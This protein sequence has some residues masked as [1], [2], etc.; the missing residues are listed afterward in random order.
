MHPLPSLLLTVWALVS[1]AA[2][3]G[4]GPADLVPGG[5]IQE[6]P[7]RLVIVGGALAGDNAEIYG[8]ILGGREGVGPLCVFPTASG[9]PQESM[10]S[11]VARLEEHGGPGAAEG[12]F[13][14]EANADEAQSESLAAR[15]R[16]CSG[17]F[18][19]GGDQS[20]IIDVF[21]PDG[22]GTPAYEAL[23]DRWR[24]GAVVSGSSAGA[25]M[26]SGRA[27]AGGNS[28]SALEAGLRHQEE[29]E[30]VWIR[31]GM[32]FAPWAIVD[33]HF[34]ARGR[35]GRLLTAVVADGAVHLGVGIDENTALVVDGDEASVVGAS[36][37][38]WL[39]ARSATLDHQSVT[40]SGLI[41]HLLG[42]GDRVS[43]STGAV[44]RAQGKATLPVS[45]SGVEAP[46]QPFARW[47]LL[48]F[49]VAWSVSD[50]PEVTVGP[51]GRP[52]ILRKGEGF[53]AV[54]EGPGGVEGTPS[55]LSAGP[56]LVDL[57]RD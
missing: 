16:D 38:I 9:V 55:G 35:W 52:I 32:D 48:H 14:T 30:G 15:I 53:Q 13:L 20:R 41:M 19:T 11:A 4:R 39:D 45:G 31:S 6:V 17:F 26:M 29:G 2:S 22:A 12:I 56:I 57:G 10:E 47:A 46:H 43:I 42:E 44:V 8:A 49:L 27:I 34:L 1:S 18:F 28:S 24:E 23:M 54:A 25:A 33:Q 50:Q 36:G 7:G 37:V 51:P 40:G 21:R 5:E 3:S